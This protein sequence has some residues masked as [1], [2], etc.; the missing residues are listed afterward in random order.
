MNMYPIHVVIFYDMFLFPTTKLYLT[1][2][3]QN[4]MLTNVTS[5]KQYLL[6][7]SFCHMHVL[8]TKCV[9]TYVVK[10]LH[11]FRVQKYVATIYHSIIKC[12]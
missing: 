4:I 3:T 2:V 7:P 12:L 9:Q 11:M 8:Y 5:N 10:I 1:L 6:I